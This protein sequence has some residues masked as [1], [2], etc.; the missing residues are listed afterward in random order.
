MGM[1][2]WQEMLSGPADA[3]GN[4]PLINDLLKEQYDVIHGDWPKAKNEIVLVLNENNELDDLT[5]YALGL[6]S[7]EEIDAIIDAAVNG[8]KLTF[9]ACCG[10][11]AIAAGAHAGNLVREIAKLAGGNGG[12]KPDSA[13]AGG[14]DTSKA[15]VALDMA[16]ELV[17][18]QLK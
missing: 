4:R 8:E 1:Q 2:M 5:L 12:G 7:E 9:C 6:L 3:N 17:K 13:M 14:K 15:Q 11:D 18:A 16:V 10:K